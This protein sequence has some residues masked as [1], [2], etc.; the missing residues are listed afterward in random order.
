[1]RRTLDE[2]EDVEFREV[3][4]SENARP[5]NQ[6]RPILVEDLPRE[7]APVTVGEIVDG[8]KG[9]IDAV[10]TAA[11]RLV[12]RGRYRKVRISRKGKQLLPDIPVAAVAALEAA[13]FYGAGVARVLAANVGAK[14]LFDIDIVNE[15]DKFVEM[16]KAALL[17]GDL[18]RSEQHFRRAIRIDDTHAEAYL[19]LGVVSRLRGAGEEAK[20]NL[21]RARELDETGPHGKR[22]DEILRTLSTPRQD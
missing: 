4:R 5:A 14:L 20:K 1:V 7:P 18:E 11:K 6:E 10:G 2:P 3:D 17:D 13:S 9:A 22:A 15:A 21:E 19:E 12:D 16:G 8:A